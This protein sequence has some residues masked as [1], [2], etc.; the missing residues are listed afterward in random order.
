MRSIF[1]PNSP[2]TYPVL[3]ILGWATIAWVLWVLLMPTVFPSPLEVLTA[4]PGLWTDGVGSELL[5]SWFV[6]M[7]ALVL[8]A[9]VGLP[10]CYLSRT[11]ILTP[12]SAF[13]AKLRFTGSAVFYLPLLMILPTAHSIKVGLL[14]LGELF[15][16][17][18]A[19]SGVVADISQSKYD[20]AS[21]LKMGPLKSLWYVNI[22]ST[23]PAAID[24]IRD[25]AGV[26]WSML[27]FVEGV[28]RSEGGIGVVLFNSEKHTDYAGFFAAVTLIILVGVGQDWLLGQVKKAACPYA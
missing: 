28:I 13:L 6:N 5:S 24:A 2:N 9:L 21:T 19:M 11:P 16:L 23:V 17:V 22:R 7:E 12:V 8:S 4:L 1:I 3:L 14:A 10:L 27:M 18:T 20:D 25:N 26:G 15:Y